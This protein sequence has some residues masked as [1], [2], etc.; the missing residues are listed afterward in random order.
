M[1]TQTNTTRSDTAIGVALALLAVLLLLA[2]LDAHAL[3]MVPENIRVPANQTLSLEAHAIG[4]QIYD[5]KPSK[6]DPARFEWV[7]RAPEADLYDVTGKRIGKHYAGP[8]WESNDGSK[9]VGQ[10]VATND[11]PD[12]KAI[13][14]L[15]LGVKSTSAATSGIGVLQRTVSVQR[16]ETVGGIAPAEGCSAAQAQKEARVPYTATYD[17][18]VER[19]PAQAA[20]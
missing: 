1:R 19:A 18:F 9:A 16:I 4:V 15:L 8:T 3:S 12:A 10:V 13:P 20:Y 17:F 2:A 5:C 14:W 11:G 7:F 6:D